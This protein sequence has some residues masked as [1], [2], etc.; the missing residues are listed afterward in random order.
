[1]SYVTDKLNERVLIN[2]TTD[3]SDDHTIEINGQDVILK[4]HGNIVG[5]V[6]IDNAKDFCIKLLTA[7]SSM[8]EDG[9]VGD[10]GLVPTG[11]CINKRV[12]IDT[13]G[14]D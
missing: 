7:L 3:L 14:D 6:N 1:M 4:K 11:H 2:K 10:L 9:T 13:N 8:D 5:Q 12:H